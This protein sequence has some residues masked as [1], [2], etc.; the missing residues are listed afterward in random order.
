VDETMVNDDG[1]AM[2]EDPNGAQPTSVRMLARGARVGRPYPRSYWRW[3]RLNWWV[4]VSA[5]IVGALVGAIAAWGSPTI[6]RSGA[7]VAATN[8]QIPSEDFGAVAEAAFTT[9][10]VLQPV[11]DAL[12][13]RTTPRELL[14]TDQLSAQAVTGSAA[15]EITARAR[16]PHLASELA[17]SAALTFEAV[18]EDKEMGTFAQFGP[19]G[20]PGVPEPSPMRQSALFGLLAGGLG[21]LTGLFVISSVREPIIS[22]EQLGVELDS[23]DVF[24]ARV[25]KPTL[26]RFL[27]GKSGWRVEPHGLVD[28]V[29]RAA[30]AAGIADPRSM[31]RRRASPR[32][33]LLAGVVV[34]KKPRV[35]A[36][37]RVLEAAA[38]D[39]PGDREAFVETSLGAQQL[40]D[41]LASAPAVVVL[42]V[43]GSAQRLVARMREEIRLAPGEKAR[44][45]VLVR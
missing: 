32:G 11:I 9:D 42:V 18:A 30:G 13:L 38:P 21:A 10:T 35:V 40:P 37:M 43:E 6:Y 34:G 20:N 29:W 12:G 22:V 44:I 7:L 15:L 25:T 36:L 41:A 28:A 14:A 31:H 45:A 8:T 24:V 16:D 33:A 1:A 39:L 3:V 27:P 19:E 26:R 23:E 17:S 2:P 5:M 4:V